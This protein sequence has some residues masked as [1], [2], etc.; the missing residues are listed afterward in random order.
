MGVRGGVQRATLSEAAQLLGIS[1]GAVRQRVRR[2]TL[3]SDKGED[4]RVYVYVYPSTNDVH[5]AGSEADQRY[6]K[7]LEDQVEYLRGQLDQ[8]RDANRENRRIIAGLTQRIPEL[9]AAPEPSRSSEPPEAP[10]TAED[11]TEGTE[12]RSAPPGAQEGAQRPWWRRWF[13]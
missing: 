3:R 10:E 11:V 1:K 13:G 8:E 4:G 7:S 5:D 2:G 12:P 6:V 9:M